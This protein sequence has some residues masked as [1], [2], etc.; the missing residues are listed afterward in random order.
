[1]ANDEFQNLHGLCIDSQVLLK[2]RIRLFFYNPVN[3]NSK[4]TQSNAKKKTFA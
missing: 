4:K 2:N 3:S 1:M